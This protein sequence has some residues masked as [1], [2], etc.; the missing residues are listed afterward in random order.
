MCDGINADREKAGFGAPFKL[1]GV[2]KRIGAK[3]VVPEHRWPRRVTVCRNTKQYGYI[4]DAQ[5]VKRDELERKLE[6]LKAKRAEL[7]EAAYYSELEA[8][9]RGLAAVYRDTRSEGF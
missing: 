7:K 4:Y 5:R 1:G 3:A 2:C 8:L 6:T 9:L